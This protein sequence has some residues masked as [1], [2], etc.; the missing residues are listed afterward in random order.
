MPRKKVHAEVQ[1]IHGAYPTRKWLTIAEGAKYCRVSEPFFYKMCELGEIPTYET[2]GQRFGSQRVPGSGRRLVNTDDLDNYIRQ[3]PVEA[4]KDMNA[5]E[6][7]SALMK[8]RAEERAKLKGMKTS[9]TAGMVEI[10]RG[11]YAHA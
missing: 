5:Q 7:L 4:R 6:R 8:W 10:Q 2:I 3:S 11:G 9:K 1:E